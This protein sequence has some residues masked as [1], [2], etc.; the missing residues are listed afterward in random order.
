[1]QRSRIFLLT[2][3]AVFIPVFAVPL[4]VDPVW[5][6]E[7]FGW[8]TDGP[9]ELVVYFGRCLG[10]LALAIAIVALRAAR[11]PAAHAWLFDLLAVAATL[12]AIVHLRGAIEDGQPLVEHVETAGYAAFAAAALVC[13][14][15]ADRATT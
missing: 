6:A 5:W 7:R 1:M 13:R 3:A 14:P 2:V 12:L 10:A 15:R 11:D 8:D 9:R 4:F